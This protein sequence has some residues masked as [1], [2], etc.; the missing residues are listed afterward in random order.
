MCVKGKSSNLEATDEP[1]TNL[2][3]KHFVWNGAEKQTLLD[4]HHELA[5]DLILYP[6]RVDGL[7]QQK[8]SKCLRNNVVTH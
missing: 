1:G 2:G 5:W 4:F 6:Y 3:E 8:T 7:Q